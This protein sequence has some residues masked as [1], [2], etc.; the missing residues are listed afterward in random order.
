[1]YFA[2]CS[3]DNYTIMQNYY[4]TCLK[5]H[6]ILITKKFVDK[7]AEVGLALLNIQTELPAL[8]TVKYNVCLE[9]LFCC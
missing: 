7:T 1:M 3:C 4:K 8:I 5:L 6:A 9:T 2:F